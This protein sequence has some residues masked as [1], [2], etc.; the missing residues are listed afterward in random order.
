MSRGEYS[1]GKRQRDSEKARKK[2]DKAERRARKRERGKGDVP[3]TT[4]E[5]MTGGL[6]TIAE[7]MAAIDGSRRVDRGASAIP[8][9][10][11]V[12]S[13]S[14]DTTREMLEQEFSQFGPVQDAVV[15]VDRDS[16]RSRGF[17]FV[18]MADR[19]H[20]SSAVSAMDGAEIDG[21]RIV[22]NVATERRR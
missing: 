10:L 1:M 13:L 3:I 11:F 7:A 14:W 16:G 5:E 18:T 8:C 22:V 6:P 9:R 19:K 15:V 4:A 12:G 20:A 17:G 21:R 2:K